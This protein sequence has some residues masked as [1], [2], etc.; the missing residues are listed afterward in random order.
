MN[1]IAPL[2]IPV[3]F[4][5][6]G[7]IAYVSHKKK[8]RYVTKINPHYLIQLKNPNAPIRLLPLNR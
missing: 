4:V 8:T 6:A 3:G 7:V 5:L 1:S 2:I